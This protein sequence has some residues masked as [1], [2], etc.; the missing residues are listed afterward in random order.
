MLT[1]TIPAIKYYDEVQNLFINFDEET[2]RLE[3]SLAAISKWE[4]KWLKP[5]LSEGEKSYEETIYYIKCMT[6]DDGV[7]DNVYNRLTNANF[8]E[9]NKYIEAPMTATTFRQEPGAKPNREIV[10]A[11]LIYYWM[12]AL[13]IPFECQN[14][15]L[16]KLLTLVRVC[17]V[18]N[19]PEKK[20]SRK[21]A[22]NRQK[23]LNAIRR[24]QAAQ[25]KG[26]NTNG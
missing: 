13:N 16:N 4:S 23:N 10:T 5:F 19:A 21:E 22:M 9:I 15:H 6:L 17:N 8:E 18:K 2:L 3:H 1:I 20:M 7:D 14:W 12:V 25:S 26:G 24:A 11:E